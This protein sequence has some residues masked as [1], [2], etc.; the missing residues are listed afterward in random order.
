MRVH[1]AFATGAHEFPGLLRACFASATSPFSRQ[2]KMRKSLSAKSEHTLVRRGQSSDASRKQI[3]MLKRPQRTRL[4][5]NV[6]GLGKSLRLRHLV[7]DKIT[8]GVEGRPPR[9]IVA[10]RIQ[11]CLG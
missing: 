9:F 4:L 2:H 8:P 1:I 11:F 10:M 5:A 3:V 6:N 7:L